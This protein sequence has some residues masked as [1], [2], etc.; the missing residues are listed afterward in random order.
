MSQDSSYYAP[1]PMT[2]PAHITSFSQ[3]LAA[4]YYPPPPKQPS[5]GVYTPATPPAESPQ[6]HR[7]TPS[8]E[9]AA[10]PTSASPPQ[11][12]IA[13]NQAAFNYNNTIGRQPVS[14]PQQDPIAYNQA[15]FNYNNT[16]GRQ[17]VSPP[18]QDPIAYN[19]AA[20]EQNHAIAMQTVSGGTPEHASEHGELTGTGGMNQDDTGVFNGGSYRISH[21]DSNSVLTVQLAMGCPLNIRPGAMIGM[22]TTITLRGTISFSW[23]KLLIGGSMTMSHYTGPG[24]LLLAPSMLGDIIALHVDEPKEWK[25]GRDALLGYTAGIGH[26]HQS[27][28][29]SKGMFSG[30]GFFIYKITGSGI[31]WMQSF[32]AIIRKDLDEGMS[33]FVDN[34]HLVAWD[35]KYKMERVASGG[36][37]SGVTSG[38]GLACRFTGPGTVYLQTRNLNAF[39]AQMKLSAAKGG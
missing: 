6:P 20:F 34:G 31:L 39:S 14:P 27:Q 25:I 16:I 11:D 7:Q 2:A 26:K 30:E 1:P 9:Y 3:S 19:Q 15:A 4:P 36:I 13:Y 28:G 17:P 22:S 12:P 35:C 33:Y 5:N 29:L 8:R 24:E 21:R 23:K 10:P 38:E 37:V 32:G 18:Q